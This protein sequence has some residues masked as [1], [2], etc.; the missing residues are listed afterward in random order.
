MFSFWFILYFVVKI[1]CFICKRFLDKSL[2][3]FC[4]FAEEET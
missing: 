1:I 2:L 3:H 4:Y